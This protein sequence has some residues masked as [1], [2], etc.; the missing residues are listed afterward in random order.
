ME[1]NNPLGACHDLEDVRNAM[2]YLAFEIQRRIG[3]DDPADGVKPGAQDARQ[4]GD[5]GGIGRLGL[6]DV[7]VSG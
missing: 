7:E 3:A 2:L 5:S 1:A 6:L 4:A